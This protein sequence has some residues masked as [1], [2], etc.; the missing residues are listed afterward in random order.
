MPT[1][2]AADQRRLLRV[3]ELDTRADQLRHQRD[4]LPAQQRADE[5]ERQIAELDG[6][7]VTAATEVSDI[8]R[9]VTKAEDDVQSVRSRQERDLKRLN[10]GA[11]S[12][13]DLQAIQSELDLLSKRIGALEDIELEAMERLEAAES[14]HAAVSEARAQA[15]D[16]LAAAIEER[17]AESARIGGELDV[18]EAERAEAA[19]GLDA[20]LLAMYE[21][22]RANHGGVG[23]AELAQGACQGCHMKLNAGDLG[24]IDKADPDDVL[25]CEEC[26]RILVRS[27]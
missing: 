10:D 25:R 8:R 14:A 22:Q 15:T 26:G 16:E 23:A 3:Q 27:S 24:A 4:N 6:R 19:E 17:D 11:G 18:V 13:K 1:A 7:V 20:G 2:P 21:K 5:R 12:A 9:D